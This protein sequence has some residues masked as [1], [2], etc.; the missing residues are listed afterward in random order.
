MGKRFH[1]WIKVK[2]FV[3]EGFLACGY[4]VKGEQ[5][6]SLVFGSMD[7]PLCYMGHVTLGV[8]RDATSR[9]STTPSCPFG[10]LPPGNE[11]AVWYQHPSVCTVTYMERTSAGNM[12]QPRFKGFRTD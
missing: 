11:D 8:P 9:F 1:D 2:N 5:V 6:T 12:R 7:V 10:V 3:D 4:I